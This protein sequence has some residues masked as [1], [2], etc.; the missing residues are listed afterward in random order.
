MLSISLSGLRCIKNIKRVIKY[1]I[2][3]SLKGWKRTRVRIIIYT[4][5]VVDVVNGS[6]LQAGILEDVRNVRMKR[7]K[8]Q[9]FTAT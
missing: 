4:C 3:T 8:M 2:Y 9:S 1:A 7:R 5:N 6:G